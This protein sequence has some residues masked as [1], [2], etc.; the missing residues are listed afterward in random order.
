MQKENRYRF[1]GNSVNL[2]IDKKKMSKSVRKNER[3]LHKVKP[4][5]LTVRG[6]IDNLNLYFTV[7]PAPE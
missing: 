3:F 2:I 4:P 7:L 6:F 1:F 5:D